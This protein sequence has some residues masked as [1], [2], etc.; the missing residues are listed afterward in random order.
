LDTTDSARRDVF[1]LYSG[2]QPSD[3]TSGGDASRAGGRSLGVSQADGTPMLVP[4]RNLTGFKDRKYFHN[5]GDPRQTLFW[6]DITPYPVVCGECSSDTD[7]ALIYYK[8]VR[9][10]LKTLEESNKKQLLRDLSSMLRLGQ[11]NPCQREYIS[12]FTQN[13]TTFDPK[14]S[15]QSYAGSLKG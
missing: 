3:D 6:M 8:L 2:A 12:Q 9:Y 1:S 10:L 11:G 7:R 15:S 4:A 13:N 14:G 5:V